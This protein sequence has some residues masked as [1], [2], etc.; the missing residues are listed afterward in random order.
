MFT[1]GW[2]AF[3]PLFLF[4]LFLSLSLLS[5]NIFFPC[6]VQLVRVIGC[7]YVWKR[8]QRGEKGKGS[9]VL[10]VAS[11][12]HLTIFS[13]GDDSSTNTRESRRPRDRTKR[14][15]EHM[16]RNKR[17]IANQNSYKLSLR[18]WRPERFYSHVNYSERFYLISHCHANVSA[19]LETVMK[20]QN[21][22]NAMI[23]VY[24]IKLSRNFCSTP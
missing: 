24:V 19:P 8:L 12:T 14:S 1:R 5:L 2:R 15:S 23:R 10:K 9:R 7:T 16:L 13:T 11:M 21:K 20:L 6:C 22:S 17:G 3:F 4:S 18:E